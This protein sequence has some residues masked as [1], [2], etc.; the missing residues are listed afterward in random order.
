MIE[1]ADWVFDSMQ[2]SDGDGLPDEWETNGV[3]TDGDGVIDLH[4]EQMG[5]DPNV[6]DVFVELD[7]MYQPKIEG[8]FFGIKYEKQ[9][10]I[11]NQVQ[12]R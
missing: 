9:K 10:E 8:S 6:P 11:L 7:W 2:D 4:L 5:A 1:I 12:K 3:D